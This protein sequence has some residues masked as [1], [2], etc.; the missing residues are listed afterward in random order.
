MAT[1]K[2]I[3]QF[4]YEAEAP[5]ELTLRV[6]DV[7]INIKNVEEGW[8]QGTL[9][10]K[11]G[12][13]PDNFV[14]IIEEPVVKSPVPTKKTKVLRRVKVTFDYEPINEDELHLVT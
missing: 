5:D 8:C 1:M 13:F 9:A 7:I 4:D 10:G 6:G 2:G 12:M 14:K 11:V 3:V